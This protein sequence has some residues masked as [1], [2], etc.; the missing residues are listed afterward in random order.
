[1]GKDVNRHCTKDD[2]QMANKHRKD[3]QYYQPTPPGPCNPVP[4]ACT[5]T[6]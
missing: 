5:I 3:A 6:S 4:L 1:M 2:A